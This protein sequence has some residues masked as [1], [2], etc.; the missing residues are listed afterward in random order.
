MADLVIFSSA[1]VRIF[2][3]GTTPDD[4]YNIINVQNFA[5]NITYQEA[6]VRTTTWISQH[7]VADAQYD[8]D[9]MATFE[10]TAFVEELIPYALGVSAVTGGGKRTYT[11]TAT[12]KP[13]YCGLQAI[14]QDPTTLKTATFT[15]KRGKVKD[16]LTA[17][18]RPGHSSQPF[19]FR[20]LP[21]TAGTYAP[22]I[23]EVDQ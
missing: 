10:A 4:T 5:A 3:V 7:V 21:D 17:L 6:L 12:S 9:V 16:F 23:I 8:A 1:K 18:T 11:G 2:P 19:A 22:W 20:S 14:A 15:L 13:A